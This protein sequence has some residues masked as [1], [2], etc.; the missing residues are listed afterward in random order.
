MP[1]TTET[2][3]VGMTIAVVTFP[4][5][6]LLTF[7]FRKTKCKAWTFLTVSLSTPY[8]FCLLKQIRN[9]L[10]EHNVQVLL[11]RSVLCRNGV[12]QYCVTFVFQVATELTLP[13]SPVSDIVEMDVCLSH[14]DMSCASFLSMPTGHESSIQDGSSFVRLNYFSD[15]LTCEGVK[16]SGVC[17]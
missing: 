17:C 5:Q 10:G 4:L 14:P 8:L 2:I 15:G 16:H 7:L 12:V 1:M 11:V 3:L 6:S 13:P 9:V